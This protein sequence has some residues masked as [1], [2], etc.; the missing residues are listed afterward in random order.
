MSI[1]KHAGKRKMIYSNSPPPQ[2]RTSATIILDCHPPPFQPVNVHKLFEDADE[3][4][5]RMDSWSSMGCS[6]PTSNSM[7]CLVKCLSSL[8][9]IA[10]F[11]GKINQGHLS[12]TN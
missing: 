3:D 6:S 8:P 5:G 12:L 2:H 1:F 10:S 4:W 9:S 11:C 7:N